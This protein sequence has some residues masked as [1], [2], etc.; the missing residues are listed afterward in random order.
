MKLDAALQ[1]TSPPMGSAGPLAERRPSI[2]M[3]QRYLSVPIDGV[4][5]PATA[6]AVQRWKYRAG[7]AAKQVTTSLQPSEALYLGG[8]L[9]EKKPGP[10][11]RAR[12]AR[13]ARVVQRQESAVEKATDLMVTWARDGQKEFPPGSNVVPWLRAVAQRYR[14]CPA[15]IAKMGYPWCM[16][17]AK[18]AGGVYG[19]KSAIAGFKGEYNVLYCPAVEAA[20]AS[21]KSLMT[22]VPIAQAKKGDL[23]LFSWNGRESQHVGRFI[24]RLNGSEIETVE[25]NTS[26]D[27]VGSQADGGAVAV[28]RRNIRLVRVVVRETA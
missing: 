6:G 11:M 26:Y 25:G 21:D 17:A 16:F 1:L 18:L 20:G 7:F 4:Y 28:R 2:R 5:G 27:D 13:R 12:A 14:W 10:L 8:R 24:R 3:V 22:I 9:A 23:V 15:W 19:G